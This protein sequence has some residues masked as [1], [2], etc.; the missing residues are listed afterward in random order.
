LLCGM[1]PAV[2]L[3][4][5]ARSVVDALQRRGQRAE[6]LQIGVHT[7]WKDYNDPLRSVVHDVIQQNTSVP[8]AF[9]DV[10]VEPQP[11]PFRRLSRG[12]ESAD[13]GRG[14]VVAL[15]AAVCPDRHAG[16][17]E[18]N[19][20]FYTIDGRIT[21]MPNM[22]PARWKRVA[23]QVASMD[24]E[25]VQRILGVATRRAAN[26]SRVTKWI[27]GVEVPCFSVSEL[28]KRFGMS[29][30]KRLAVLTLD[31]EGFDV[32]TLL[33][34]N[35]RRVRPWLLVYEHKHSNH[36]QHA[37]L[38]RKLERHH[39]YTCER[40]REN[41]FCYHPCIERLVGRNDG[42][43]SVPR[44]LGGRGRAACTE[45]TAFRVPRLASRQ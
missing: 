35:L 21:T 13:R 44:L 41:S 15:N 24:R 38:M 11:V 23:T 12:A 6:M 4:A 5:C 42:R 3:G 36:T 17:A 26:D 34:L 43:C 30:D 27:I 29:G 40:D 25:H 8:G 2:T 18:R 19:I 10:L 7:F 14:V 32:A 37:G 45:T 31:M 33:Q 22:M 28:L 1:P 16:Q 20:T 9:L 39:N